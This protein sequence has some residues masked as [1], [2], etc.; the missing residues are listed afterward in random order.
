MFFLA[1]QRPRFLIQR[2]N[3]STEIA[4][5]PYS[6]HASERLHDRKSIF[7]AHAST[8]PSNTLLPL[9]LEVL[10]ASPKLKKATHCMYAYRTSRSSTSI[11]SS[12]KS[13]QVTGQHDGG[14]SG[15][16]NYLARLLDV[17][18]CENTVV[19]VSRWYGGV[20]LGGD[21][22]RRITH[23]AKEALDKGGFC[24]GKDKTNEA[25]G[26]PKKKTTKKKK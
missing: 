2:R 17:T 10:T 5:W 12:S 21:R 8:L 9:F 11:S 13:E 3:L 20:Q 16:G 26:S 7:V 15:S 22:W 25:T 18:G 4:D 14:E 1:R 6:I 24:G 19:V 23:V